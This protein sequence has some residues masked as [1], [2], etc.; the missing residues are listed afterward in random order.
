MRIQIDV[1]GSEA[2]RAELKD[3]GRKA[4]RAMSETLNATANAAQKEIRGG[5][6]VFTLRRKTFVEQTIYRQ[7]GVDFATT[8]KLQAVVRVNPDRDF[9]AQHED[10]TP[11]TARSGSSVAIPMDAVQQHARNGIIPTKFRPSGLRLHP[12]V[13]K[14]VTPAGVFLVRNRPGKGKGRLDGWRTEFLYRLKGSVP[15]KPR[16]RFHVHAS[17]AI[18][19][20]FERLALK[21]ID[22]VL[23]APKSLYDLRPLSVTKSGRNA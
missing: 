19:R 2:V 5:L 14:V 16:L 3:I 20:D 22:L 17:T 1:K 7:R 6:D 4:P 13:R 15:L 10:G 12:Q 9:L 23:G 18:D 8:K 21:H 11:K